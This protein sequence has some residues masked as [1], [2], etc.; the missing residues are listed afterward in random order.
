MVLE[1]ERESRTCVWYGDGGASSV[2]RGPTPERVRSN[3]SKTTTCF[4]VLCWVCFYLVVLL[5]RGTHPIDIIKWWVL[6]GDVDYDFRPN[7]IGQI[8]ET[9]ISS[10]PISQLPNQVLPSFVFWVSGDAWRCTFDSFNCR[11][12]FSKII[13]FLFVERRKKAFN[14][15]ST[16]SV[17]FL[18]FIECT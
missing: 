11:I 4:V 5:S 1:R 3:F 17:F 8:K 2:R 10:D 14:L 15:T 12:F 7:T 18:T 16:S 6:T 9:L 13:K